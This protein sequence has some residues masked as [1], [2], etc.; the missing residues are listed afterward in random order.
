M[1][2]AIRKDEVEYPHAEVAVNGVGL[3]LLVQG[4][5]W[6]AERQTLIV[7][8]LHLEKGSSFASRGLLIPPYDTAATL[9]RLGA[10]IAEWQP[11]TVIAL[12]DNFHDRFGGE[13]MAA[14]DRE[15]LSALQDGRDWLWVTGNHDPEPQAG[16]GGEWVD[17]LELQGL[18]FR[19]E[20]HPRSAQPGLF[21][22]A[23]E[24]EICG[25]LHP[26]AKVRARGRSVRRSCFVTDGRRLVM[27]AFG[28]L[29]GGLDIRDRAYK[30]VFGGE[31][32][33]VFMRGR[34]RLFRHTMSCGY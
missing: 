12:G 26:S 7:S 4:A 34:D 6:W 28:V 8:D 3:T 14:P 5:I 29:T 1:T 21:P 23:S 33:K 18:V 25:H 32:V 24:G 17:T 20:P 11:K 13:R 9:K 16:V 10:L 15:T 30:P 31:P 19:H 27:P 2:L 22:C